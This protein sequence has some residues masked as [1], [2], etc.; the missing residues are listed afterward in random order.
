MPKFYGNIGYC[1]LTETAPGVHTEE[2]TVRPYYGDF[3]RN[4][5]RL[6]GTEHL[7]DDLVISSQLSIVFSAYGEYPA[8]VPLY[9]LRVEYSRYQI[10]GQCPVP[11]DK[12]LSGHCDR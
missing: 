4:T 12:T 7:N 3:I 5:R 6:Q 10:C 1:K 11:M 8:E 2:I 9:P